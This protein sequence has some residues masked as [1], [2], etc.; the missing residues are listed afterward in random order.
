MAL[1]K[2]HDFDPNYRDS[3]DGEDIK[4]LDVYSTAGDEK[5]GK[6]DDAL[7]D[8]QG[9]FRYL[10]VDTGF[11]I[12]GKK[13]MLPVGLSRI[14]Y[15]NHRVHANLTKE[16]V[17]NLPEFTDDLKLDRT[18]E[19]QVRNVYRPSSGATSTRSVESS[20]VA[21][22]YSST[23]SSA[24]RSVESSALDPAYDPAYGAGTAPLDPAYDAAVVGGDVNQSTSEDYNRYYSQEPNLYDLNER[25]HQNLRL[26]QERLLANKQRVKTGDVVVGKRVETETQHV[27]VP[28]EKERV[29]IE[30]TNPTDLG[31]A[32]PVGAAN[33]Q[34]GEVA[35]IEVY[36][37]VA[38]IR[39]EAFVREEVNVRKEVDQD[40]VEADETLRREELDINT[41]GN[42]V[43]DRRPS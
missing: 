8:E 39:K 22:G 34:D 3:F 35:R 40:S 11:W 7:V 38:D 6:I 20:S 30:R 17:E 43:I 41:Q 32:A 29:V 25:D 15:S 4:G 42:P 31:A 19:D 21:P 24:T 36:E 16:Q 27:S 5:I 14:D 26:Y 37:E 10:I 12:F 2:I 28:V 18:Y 33:F 9:Q 1:Y 23:S 13:I